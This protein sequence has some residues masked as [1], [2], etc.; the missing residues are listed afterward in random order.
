MW[1]VLRIKLNRPWVARKGTSMFLASTNRDFVRPIG[2]PTHNGQR[3]M[4]AFSVIRPLANDIP[5]QPTWDT[6]HANRKRAN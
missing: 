1:L 5:E 6:H 2:H 4:V 3:I